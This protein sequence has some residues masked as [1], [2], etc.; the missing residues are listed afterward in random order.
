MHP[1]IARS[2]TCTCTIDRPLVH[3]LTPVV[4]IKQNDFLPI[5]RGRSAAPSKTKMA[6]TLVG[7]GGDD[8]WLFFA[9]PPATRLGL[10]PGPVYGKALDIAD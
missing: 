6:K 2:S 1:G 4:H 10:L 3:F 9:K 7:G 5:E 8:R